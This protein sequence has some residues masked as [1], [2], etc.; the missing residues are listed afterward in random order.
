MN[1][2]NI[3]EFPKPERRETILESFHQ[4]LFCALLRLKEHNAFNKQNAILYGGYLYGF[5]HALEA[6][7]DQPSADRFK[8]TSMAITDDID[9]MKA[10]L[11]DLLLWLAAVNQNDW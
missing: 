7:G 4:L 1:A 3:L 11:E 8:S 10:E 6:M 2:I 9:M 5:G